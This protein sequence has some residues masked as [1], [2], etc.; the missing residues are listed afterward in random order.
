MA[1]DLP[2]LRKSEL[3]SACSDVEIDTV[4]ARSKEVRLTPGSLLFAEEDKADGVW[5][6]L[7]GELGITKVTDGSEIVVDQLTTG[8]YL[9]EISLLTGAPAA[10]RA[11]AKGDVEL[12]KIPGAAFYDLLRSC[13]AVSQ[14]VLRTMAERVQRIERL[15]Q[16]RE[17]MAGLGTLAAGLAHELKNPAT[18]AN[19]AIG[20]LSEQIA[21]L[22]ELAEKLAAHPW[23]PGELG[24]LSELHRVTKSDDEAG[25]T[26]G[27][28]ERQEREEELA[29][30]LEAHAIADPWEFA[31]MLVDCG[32][33][34]EMLNKIAKGCDLSALRDAFA[35]ASRSTAIRQLLGEAKESTARIVELVKA[36]KAYSYVDAST[37]RTADVHEGIET[38]LTIL[39]SRLRHASA[40]VDR[41]YDRSLPPLQTYGTELSQVWTNLLDNAADAVGANGGRVRVRTARDGDGILVEIADSGAGIPAE[42][43][44]KIFDPFFTT[45]GA[46]KG[47]GLGLEIAKR[48]VNRHGGT[49]GVTSV[50]GDTRFSIRLPLVP[51][52]PAA[53][54]ATAQTTGVTQAIR[55]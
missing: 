31:P 42:V 46:G 32:V 38:S 53:A 26:L 45:K 8:G 52:P 23:T 4:V 33:T 25:R 2:T 3:L 19:R 22:D 35:W 30:W 28:I 12:L 41:Q 34:V 18:A 29:K 21:G 39:A 10:H 14:T 37:L 55:R 16:E 44:K 15:M 27:A 1:I 20:L 17:R 47:T 54:P 24:L 43:Q 48:I 11:R 7:K 9:G 5:V 13:S 6:V 51:P 50:P 49:I 40:V 36:I